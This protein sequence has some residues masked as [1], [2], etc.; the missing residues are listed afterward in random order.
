[1]NKNIHSVVFIKT[2]KDAKTPF[3][4]YPGDAGY[5]LYAVEDQVVFANAPIVIKTGIRVALPK[6][7]YAEIHTRSSQGLKGTRN[8]LGVVDEGYRGEIAPIMISLKHIHVMKGDKIGQLI[9]KKRIEANFIEVDYLPKSDRG[10][11]GFGST[12]K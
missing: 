7:Y 5:D 2:H 11:K 9:L 12:G 1:M 10:T 3:K 6:G 8:H 4:K